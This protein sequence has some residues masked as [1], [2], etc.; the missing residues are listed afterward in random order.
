MR[1][2]IK[3]QLAAALLSAVVFGLMAFFARRREQRQEIG[4]HHKLY[5][6][7]LNPSLLPVGFFIWWAAIPWLMPNGIQWMA[8]SSAQL[9]LESVIYYAVLPALLPLLR[10]RISAITCAGLWLAPN[11]VYVALNARIAPGLTPLTVFV[12]RSAARIVGWT[13]AAGFAAVM[14]WKIT[15][16][17]VF[18]ARLLKGAREAGERER[19]ALQKERIRTGEQKQHRLLV[20][21]AAATPLTI[22]GFFGRTRIVLPERE[23]TDGELA[24]ILRHEMVHIQREDIWLKF[25][26]VFLTALCWWNPLM[27]ITAKNAARDVE[28]GCDESALLGESESRRR[29]YAELIL[30]QAGD[31]RGFTTCLSAS[32]EALRY[33]LQGVMSPGKKRSGALL[34]ALAVFAL[35]AFYGWIAVAVEAGTAEELFFGGN[36]A[37]AAQRLSRVYAPEGVM[38]CSDPEALTEYLARTPLYFTAVNVPEAE[39]YSFVYHRET[40]ENQWILLYVSTNGSRLYVSTQR[41]WYVTPQGLDMDYIDSLL[42][43]KD[44]AKQDA[45]DGILF[46]AD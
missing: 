26:M 1:V 31:Q 16:H 11:A 20:S 42:M 4:W 18:R 13:W 46:S 19:E 12:P 38:E 34:V 35:I 45:V 8:I 43:P 21:P 36:S 22:D 40:G 6:P 14:L 44:S 7:V 9:A 32:A 10:K 27:W 23:Y 24:L 30:S 25:L 2:E 29:E 15:E 33:R 17:L 5:A 41:G 37:A 28:L 3:L 39:D